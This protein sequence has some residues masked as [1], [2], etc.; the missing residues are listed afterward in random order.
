MKKLM[1]LLFA[2]VAMTGWPA[3]AGSAVEPASCTFTNVRGEAVA[4]V[5]AGTI[6]RGETLLMTNCA[7]CTTNS[8]TAQTL[9]NV[10]VS[11]AVGNLSTSTT[12][13]ATVQNAAAGTWWYSLPCP[14][15]S[16][17]F[18]WVR[19]VD[20]NTNSY[21]YPAKSFAADVNPF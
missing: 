20:E 2:V 10:T 4:S 19:V 14:D 8:S 1:A 9:T 21:I 18:V 17:F 12:Y 16:Q 6:Y 11:I 3:Q 7:V 15:L 13:T 5:A